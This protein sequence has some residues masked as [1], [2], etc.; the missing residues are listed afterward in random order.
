MR[1]DDNL[2][3]EF[4]VDIALAITG[5]LYRMACLNIGPVSA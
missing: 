5:G 4:N 1:R 2:S 3:G